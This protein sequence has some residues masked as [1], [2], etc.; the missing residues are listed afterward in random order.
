MA[1]RVSCQSQLSESAVRVIELRF[2]TVRVRVGGVRV[3]GKGKG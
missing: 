2:I 3:R 1:V